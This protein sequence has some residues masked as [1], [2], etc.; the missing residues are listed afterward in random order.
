MCE[1]IYSVNKKQIMEKKPGRK[2]TVVFLFVLIF[3]TGCDPAVINSF[4]SVPTTDGPIIYAW[5]NSQTQGYGVAGCSTL[6]CHSEYSWPQFFANTMGWT[7]ENQAYGGTDC[8]DLTYRGTSLSIWDMKIDASSL[9]IY[10]H[11]RNDQAQYGPLP[12]RVAYARGCIEAQTAWLA[13]PESNKIRGNSTLAS[14]TGVWIE[15][16]QNSAGSYTLTAG[17]TKT[18]T[19]TG[20][21]IYLATARNVGG[22]S[23]MYTVAVDGNL[24]EDPISNSITFDQKLDV[25]GESGHPVNEFMI[26]NFIRVPNLGNAKHT[27]VYTCTNPSVSGCYIFYAAGVASGSSTVDRPLVYSLSNLFN[28]FRMSS[29]TM[30]R[31]VTLIYY[32]QWK[33]MVSELSGDGLRVIGIDAINTKTYNPFNDSQPDGI[34]PNLDGHYRIAVAASAA[35]TGLNVLSQ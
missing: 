34:H 27:I 2:R 24:V 5:G 28:S 33:Q 30:T 6:I 35:G 14:N 15:A 7:L 9:N 25:G 11:F 32:D 3:L 17:A 16:T 23:T 31:A 12:Y 26:Q 29:G 20:T 10:G 21:V 1:I 4:K 18:F 13:I 22:D 8:A 19:L